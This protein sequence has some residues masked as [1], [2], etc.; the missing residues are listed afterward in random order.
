MLGMR[1]ANERNR[2]RLAR[3]PHGVEGGRLR[4]FQGRRANRK[5]LEGF[6]GADSCC[7]RLSRVGRHKTL[8][9]PIPGPFHP[10][11]QPS[12]TH[13]PAAA[14]T[15]RA[16]SAFGRPGRACSRRSE[17]ASGPPPASRVARLP[18]GPNGP[19]S[20]CWVAPGA[21]YEGASRAASPTAAASSRGCASTPRA[22]SSSSN[23][24][25]LR[26]RYTF[27]AHPVTPV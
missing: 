27:S 11:P 3:R 16:E 19:L 10:L 12:W 2:A 25:A 1:A 18:A 15:G 5:E 23:C 14:P 24:S 4:T 13:P 9:A 21:L 6:R 20:P 8:R 7:Y 17:A 26:R 22:L